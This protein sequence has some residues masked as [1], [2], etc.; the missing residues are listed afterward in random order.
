MIAI[1]CLQYPFD[2]SLFHH[3]GFC[4]KF[5]FKGKE[6]SVPVDRSLSSFFYFRY[7]YLYDRVHQ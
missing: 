5:L 6:Q 3:H 1:F 2:H 4:D 7:H